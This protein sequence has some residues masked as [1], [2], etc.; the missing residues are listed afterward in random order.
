MLMVFFLAKE[1]DSLEER[2][3]AAL[4]SLRQGLTAAF[5]KADCESTSDGDL[6]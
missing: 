5:T 1:T 6:M 3:P 2:R 4:E